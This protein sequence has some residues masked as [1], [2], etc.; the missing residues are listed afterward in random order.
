MIS[1]QCTGSR[2]AKNVEFKKLF[3]NMSSFAAGLQGELFFKNSTV[4]V[5]ESTFQRF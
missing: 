2:F 1:A 3:D 4:F 5:V